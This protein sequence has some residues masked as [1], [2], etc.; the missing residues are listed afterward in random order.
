[1][2]ECRLSEFY[3]PQPECVVGA[4]GAAFGGIDTN[5]FFKAS[6][7]SETVTKPYARTQLIG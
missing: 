3:L 5:L 2:R 4:D 7:V 6:D 1:M